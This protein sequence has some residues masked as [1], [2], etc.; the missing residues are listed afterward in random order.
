MTE[1]ISTEMQAVHG[2]VGLHVGGQHPKGHAVLQWDSDRRHF[3][4]RAGTGHSHAAARNFVPKTMSQEVMHGI[5]GNAVFH[6]TTW[7]HPIEFLKSLDSFWQSPARVGPC[8]WCLVRIGTVVRHSG[9]SQAAW[10]RDLLELYLCAR[11]R[12]LQTSPDYIREIHPK[13]G[14]RVERTPSRN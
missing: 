14:M 3:A 8:H 10:G 2:R 12:V 7:T 4:R 9:V 5:S 11:H 13:A 6:V 1:R